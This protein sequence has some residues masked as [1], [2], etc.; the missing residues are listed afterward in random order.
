MTDGE[1]GIRWSYWDL[2]PQMSMRAAE[3]FGEGLTVREMAAA[4]RISKSE[5]G[6]LRIRAF[7]DGLLS[8]ERAVEIETATTTIQ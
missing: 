4:L 8:E 5:A 3:L 1:D 2:K 7:E 6:R